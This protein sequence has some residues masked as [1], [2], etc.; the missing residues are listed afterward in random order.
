MGRDHKSIST[1]SGVGFLAGATVFLVLQLF[2]LPGAT[3]FLSGDQWIYLVG[4]K[5]MLEGQVIYRDFFEFLPAGTHLV[6]WALMSVF[7]TSVWIPNATL[8]LA[9]VCLAGLSVIISRHIFDGSLVYLPGLLFVV[10]AFRS[11]LDGTHHWLSIL[12]VV[13][14]VGVLIEARTPARLAVAGFLCGIASNFTPTRGFL[15]AVGF[16]LH[17]VWEARRSKLPWSSLWIPQVVLWCSLLVPFLIFNIYFAWKAGDQQFLES[18]I[19]FLAQ[20][21]TKDAKWN[22]LQVFMTEI[23][24]IGSWRRLPILAVWLFNQV[25]Q[26]LIYLLI[27]FRVW[28]SKSLANDPAKIWGKLMLL[29]TTG[30]VL[31]AGV[32]AA[33][34]TVRLVSISLPALILFVWYVRSWGL[35][36]KIAV[37]LLWVGALALMVGAV[38]ERQGRREMILDLPSGRTSFLN[39]VAYERFRWVQEHARPGEY[40]FEGE[41]ADMYYPLLLRNPAKVPFLTNTEYTRPQQVE[42]VVN[43]LE[44]QRVRF[45]LWSLVLDVPRGNQVDDNLGPL[46]KYLREHYRPVQTFSDLSEIWERVE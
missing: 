33:P 42:E 1:A 7:G 8:V 44:K 23:P 29:N 20:Y 36:G 21:Y 28:R 10:L 3:I 46:R 31:F 4:A 15:A 22:T 24:Q 13:M 32:A 11:G 26:P 43:S 5:R 19:A 30:L 9:G 38:V 14:A 37:R 6:Y 39:S 35:A 17:L 12:P 25:L 40:F 34:G 45:V 18:T 16:S 2:V 41:F 27:L